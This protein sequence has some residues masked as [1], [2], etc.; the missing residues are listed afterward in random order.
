MQPPPLED[1]TQHLAA[2]SRG[3]AGA[4][5][6]AL[7]QLYGDLKRLAAHY[8]AAERPDHTLE[9]T[10]LVHEAYL[11][12]AGQRAPL[13]ESRGHF[14]AIAAT[15]MRRILVDHARAVGS[16]KR[17]AGVVKLEL[18][19]ALETPAATLAQLGEIDVAL[20]RLETLDKTKAEVVE[21][22]VFGGLSLAETAAA[23]GCSTATVGRHWR[24]ARAWLIR[25]LGG[26][27]GA[28]A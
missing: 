15:L 19:A 14:L 21:M 11:R 3:D 9:P 8:L 10:A 17:G 28:T 27:R 4:G 18:G 13:W 24:T 12:L 25:E 26:G 16:Q 23:L 5:G 7:E 20:M 22:R 1:V 2:W 6:A